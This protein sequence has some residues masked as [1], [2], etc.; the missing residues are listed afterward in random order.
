MRF[1]AALMTVCLL[2]STGSPAFAKEDRENKSNK[3]TPVSA[4]VEYVNISPT[5]T[6]T[7]TSSSKLD[8][9]DRKVQSIVKDK[10][11]SA[12]SSSPVALAT[13]STNPN[14]RFDEAPFKVPLAGESISSLSG[15]IDV[16]SVDFTLPGR[17]GL[18]F[19]LARTYDNNEAQLY[20]M[21]FGERDASG[22]AI[23]PGSKTYQRQLYPIGTGWSFDLPMLIDSNL[24]G[25]GDGYLYLR[26]HG[27][28]Y[29]FDNPLTG[30][31]WQ[32]LTAQGG[33][34]TFQVDG[35]KSQ[36]V[37][38]SLLDGKTY[39]FDVTG[40]VIEIQD[41]NGNR[42]QFS[43][44]YNSTYG[45]D[46]LSKIWDEVGNAITIAY[47]QTAV[48]VTQG[49]KQV[50]YKKQIAP[51]TTDR[52]LLTEVAD[53]AGRRTVYDYQIMDA[54]FD[55]IDY[56]YPI[57]THDPYAL[58][59]GIT[60]P[61]GAKS[62]FQYES[63]PVSRY[64]LGGGSSSLQQFRAASAEER[65]MTVS[66]TW[67]TKD[68]T[69]VSY[70][71]DMGTFPGWDFD[72]S[73]ALDHG[74]N[75]TTYDF[76]RNYQKWRETTATGDLQ[77]V[78]QYTYDSTRHLPVPSQTSTTYSKAGVNSDT[79]TASYTYD[80]Y[81]NV[82]TEAN[83]L[84]VTTTYGYDAVTHRLSS[85]LQ[86]VDSSQ[87]RKTEYIR[88]SKGN[89]TQMTVTDQSGRVL[90]KEAYSYDAYGNRLTK[91]ADSQAGSNK[92]TYEY[93]TLYQSAFLTKQTTTQVDADGI[94][95]DAVQQMEYDPAT[96]KVTKS[97]DAKGYVTT[98]QYDVLG[99]LTQ[100]VNPDLTSM[101]ISYDD[102]QNQV[103]ATDE[104]GQKTYGKWNPLGWK[105]ELGSVV[106]GVNQVQSRFGYD[107]FGR[108]AWSD[109]ALAYRTSY[110]Y[111]GLD[112]QT[113]VTYADGTNSSV[114]YDDLKNTVTTIDADGSTVRESFDRLG[115]SLKKESVTASGTQVLQT[116]TYNNVGNVL[117]QTDANGNTTRYSYDAVGELTSVVDPQG[118]QTQYA[119]D[120][121][122]HL[123]T[124]TYP[125]GKTEQ[126]QYDSAGHVVRKTDP[127][128]QVETY[129]YDL[130]GNLIKQLDR[131]GQTLTT[132]Y[133][134]R[135]LPTKKTAGADAVLYE[136][137]KTG[138]RTKM[139][140]STGVTAYS[141]TPLGDLA[142]VQLQDGKTISYTYD[143]NRNRT[144]MKDPFGQ[145]I[146]Y[147]YDN[148][149]RVQSVA[150]GQA[151]APAEASFTY[152]KA[153]ALQSVQQRNGMV[154]TF[155]FDALKRTT[156]LQQKKADGTVQN[157]FAYE[158]DLAGN[159]TRKTE[160]GTGQSFTYD[161][162]NRILTS[163]QFNETYSYDAR[164]NRQT[165]QSDQVPQMTDVTYE[166]DVWNR[167]SKVTTA[168]GNVVTY[169]YNGDGL[170]Y[171]R[172]ENGVTVRYYYANDQMIAEAT[173]SNGTPVLK[174]R[175][176][177][178]GNR[179]IAREDASGQKAYYLH[180]AHGDVTELRDSNGNTK[181]VY[182]YDIWGNLL[183][184][185][186]TVENPFRYSGEYWDQTTSLQYLRARWYDPAQG[187]FITEDTY[188]GELKNSLS[189]NLYSYVLNNPL[190]YVDPT[191]KMTTEDFDGGAGGGS[192]GGGGG[193]LVVAIEAGELLKGKAT[194]VYV[195]IKD[196][197]VKYVGI[198][199]DVAKRAAQHTLDKRGFGDI[200][201]ITEN[202][203]TRNQARAIEQA[204]INN[205]E[206]LENKI[207]SI[208]PR[209]DW[210]DEAVRWGENWLKSIGML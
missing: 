31:P 58:L 158:Y 180:N 177:R 145:D 84:G 24:L 186:E 93:S 206:N 101:I 139:T 162:L 36:Y 126:K 47:S 8:E 193:L 160:N 39:Y 66:G 52:E 11:K 174:A 85:V 116:S 32:D 72:F 21:D 109:D 73:V 38:N 81:G 13:G 3:S 102:L 19:E 64:L 131:K 149:N 96:G 61:T 15:S 199:Y 119:Y 18:G 51:G 194:S 136:Y 147:Q 106:N 183:A 60:Y 189:L 204:I 14:N 1:L 118:K 163:T 125:D 22:Q 80:D 209:R 82:L 44:T 49:S 111:D 142:S 43:Y 143:A 59:T 155:T 37:L 150:E 170:L 168:E 173:I 26:W 178:N 137:D 104:N 71:K 63:A 65:M 146:F 35:R 167:L 110:G 202:Q 28:L 159:Q 152:T 148:R 5:A 20:G 55:Q 184:A 75:K 87:S 54:T 208:S 92:T 190:R 30:Y 45:S 69:D 56:R 94:A 165:L 4:E 9:L 176:I 48:T 188:E 123:I 151:T 29:N 171:E 169:R 156:G 144:Q 132:E 135:N 76:H 57:R 172:T 97:T 196:D 25:Y 53:Q 166:Y 46:L 203:V 154:S 133:N 78:T 153:G 77:K 108:Q 99:R 185:T 201:T 205:F 114:Q 10:N 17:G 181:N 27:G 88:D 198:S 191:G 138:H 42:L 74:R 157:S 179:L 128:G 70:V 90:R 34:S 41:A 122:G 67:E 197:V 105:T 6:S 161:S 91:N 195:A 68:H 121:L 12:D 7:I 112:R 16:R 200:I 79:F 50:V 187:R 40:R 129:Y 140:D 130:N 95:S 86:P 33:V 192:S 124:T 103:T 98:Y 115:R 62:V 141:Y 83:V 2:T 210:Y 23:Y 117:N 127:L 175:Y 207:N 100:Q 107:E 89:V 164:G 134:M 182:T 113:I 120:M